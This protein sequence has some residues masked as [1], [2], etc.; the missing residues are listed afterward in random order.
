MKLP[1]HSDIALEKLTRYLL[2][3]QARADKSRF[4]A[5]AGYAL[6]NPARLMEDLRSQI[7]H[8]D[9]TPSASNQFGEYY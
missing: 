8:L 1:A 2:V 9:A 3:P 4:L 7:L 6:G 5:K